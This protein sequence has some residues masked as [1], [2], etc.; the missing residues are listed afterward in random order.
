MVCYEADIKYAQREENKR[1]NEIRRDA[2]QQGK[3]SA[4]YDKMC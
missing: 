1:L 3:K 4:L 2:K